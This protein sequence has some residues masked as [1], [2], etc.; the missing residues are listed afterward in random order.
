MSGVW[1]DSPLGMPPISIVNKWSG[2]TDPATIAANSSI[3]SISDAYGFAKCILGGTM[4]NATYKALL[5]LTGSGV[6]DF[7]ALVSMNATNREL[8]L[9]LILDGIQVF[10]GA[11][12]VSSAQ[13]G[14]IG[15][16]GGSGLNSVNLIRSTPFKSSFVAWAKITTGG[17]N[18]CQIIEAHQMMA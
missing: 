12:T 5:S 1:G 16:G 18:L 10:E 15:I 7:C 9:K 17:D 4:A 2:I 3:T 8:F 6:I 14:I 13:A 11:A